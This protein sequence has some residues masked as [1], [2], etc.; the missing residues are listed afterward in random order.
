MELDKE[1]EELGLMFKPKEDKGLVRIID[2]TNENDPELKKNIKKIIMNKLKEDETKENDP[3]L[4]VDGIPTIEA[5]LRDMELKDKEV[6][7]KEETLQTKM[8]KK[9]VRLCLVQLGFNFMTN[10]KDLNE[11][12]RKRLQ[13]LMRAYEGV[14]IEQIDKEFNEVCD[15][16]IFA[17]PK[18][19]Y[20]KL[21]VYLA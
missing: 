7:I 13:A 2:E 17:N 12:Q 1:I 21:P 6:V 15:E 18:I 5:Q 10:V 19:D 4:T 3:D 16:H 9:V 8:T 20:S 11:Y 14:E